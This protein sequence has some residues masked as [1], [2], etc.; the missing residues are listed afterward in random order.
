MQLIFFFKC[1][2]F[3]NNEE[4]ETKYLGV[5]KLKAD[6]CVFKIHEFESVNKVG[7]FS[8]LLSNKPE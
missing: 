1:A 3:N 5:L 7:E 8:M 2:S 6:V 4:K